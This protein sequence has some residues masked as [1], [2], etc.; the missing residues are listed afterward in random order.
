MEKGCAVPPDGVTK[1][2]ADRL[3]FVL[4]AAAVHWICPGPVPWPP[5]VIVTQLSLE[6]TVQPRT[7]SLVVSVIAPDPPDPGTVAEDGV[8]AS[9]PPDWVTLT[10]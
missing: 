3:V 7:G 8:M 1:I 9:V 2:V 5:D 10:V 6:L 4:F